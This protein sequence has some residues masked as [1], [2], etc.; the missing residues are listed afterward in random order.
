[1]SGNFHAR[2][3]VGE[4]VRPLGCGLRGIRSSLDVRAWVECSLTLAL[5][6]LAGCYE[7]P[8]PP[9][10][11]RP[12]LVAHAAG[13]YRHKS[14][15]NSFDAL[16]YNYQ[17]GHRFFEIDFC[18]TRDGHLVAI[19]DWDATY[20]RLFPGA[21]NTKPPSLAT[22]ASL[23]MADGE[24]QI[25]LPALSDW[26]EEHPDAY[27]VTDIKDKSIKG[28]AQ[29]RDVL[30]DRQEQVIPQMYHSD[31]YG[32][33][34]DL[35]YHTIIYTLYATRQSTTEIIDSMRSLPLFAVTMSEKRRDF[36][37]LLS[38][39]KRFGVFVYAHTFNTVSDYERLR[40]IGV[41][42][43]YTDFLYIDEEGMPRVHEK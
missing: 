34:R 15:L 9:E 37:T 7:W 36:G 20:K 12:L 10:I 17:L 19:H 4:L 3:N 29:M 8:E 23:A 13:G 6:I 11:T 5:A 21:D 1:M 41:A 26:L 31:T 38:Q 30:G 42:G 39:A 2:N 16:E 27:I 24:T 32:S 18:W 40:S 22:F 25:T 28:L 35:G 33:I 14:Y 43:V